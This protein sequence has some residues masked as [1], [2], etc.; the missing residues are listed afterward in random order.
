MQ[1]S[2]NYQVAF[3]TWGGFMAEYA[4]EET[5]HS[6]AA[7]DVRAHTDDRSCCSQDAA[8]SP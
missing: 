1:P 3:L 4:I 7:A 2:E 5:G 6:D 8:L